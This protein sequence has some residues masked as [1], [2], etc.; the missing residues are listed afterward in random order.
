MQLDPKGLS[1]LPWTYHNLP[2]FGRM[3]KDWIEDANGNIVVENVG[4]IDGPAIVEAMNRRA[5]SPSP[6]PGVVEALRRI[7]QILPG[8]GSD[9]VTTAGNRLNAAISIASEALASLSQPA[10]KEERPV[11]YHDW[12]LS[13]SLSQ[14]AKGEREGGGL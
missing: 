3:G 1:P 11:S 12:L 2:T 6:A 8:D 5:P 14:P 7:S 9:T 4:R 13:T 10:E